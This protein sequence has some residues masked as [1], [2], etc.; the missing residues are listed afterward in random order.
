M[1]KDSPLTKTHVT[2]LRTVYGYLRMNQKINDK[3]TQLLLSEE[4]KN[5][6][7][8]AAL[9]ISQAINILNNVK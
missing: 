1:T 9:L 3:A 8:E 5:R 2:K 4:N 7:E 6:F